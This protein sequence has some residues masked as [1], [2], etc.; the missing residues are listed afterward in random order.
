MQNIAEF[1]EFTSADYH[2]P[3]ELV[4]LLRECAYPA[5]TRGRSESM[6]RYD[7]MAGEYHTENYMEQEFSL[8]TV[9]TPLCGGE[10][11]AQLYATYKLRPDVPS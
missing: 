1:C 6:M 2:V 8:G 11:T 7:G 10:Q 3:E 5:R 9:D 4:P